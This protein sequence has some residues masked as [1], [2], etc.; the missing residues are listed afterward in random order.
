MPRIPFDELPDDARIWIFGA[1][2]SLSTDTQKRMLSAVDAWLDQWTAHGEP[3]TCGRDW[4]EGRFLVV[5]VDQR[6]AGA[7]GC[8]IDALFHVLKGLETTLGT[9]FRGG[10]RIFYRVGTESIVVA[11]RDSF[12]AL[13]SEGLVD[14]TTPVFDTALS[15]AG[16]YRRAFEVPLGGSWH[17]QLI[18]PATGTDS[19]PQTHHR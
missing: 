4:R 10:D 6:T 7:S 19:Q 2:D 3:L 5:G 13:A 8:S 14:E 17:R 9:T 12:A 16:S 11:D 1:S 18:S 15:D